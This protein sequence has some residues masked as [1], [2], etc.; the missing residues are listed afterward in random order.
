MPAPNPQPATTGVKIMINITP[1]LLA[2]VKALTEENTSLESRIKG[3]EA[4]CRGDCQTI[5]G[6]RNK[7]ASLES[8]IKGFEADCR[9]DCQTID[10]LRNKVASLESEN[11]EL[12][13]GP[14]H[15]ANNLTIDEIR[16]TLSCI[17]D[18][19]WATKR[20]GIIRMVRLASGYSLSLK[21]AKD[22][23]EDILWR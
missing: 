12:R 22:M 6:L 7:V 1:N 11:Q 13:N 19:A 2:V 5:D 20:I 21:D 23:V 3:F 4:D 15:S 14:T 16:S 17:R 18:G 8:R 10:G 9:G